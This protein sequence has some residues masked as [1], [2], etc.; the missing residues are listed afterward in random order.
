MIRKFKKKFSLFA[1]ICMSCFIVNN[2]TINA[3]NNHSEVAKEQSKVFM[4]GAA[5]TNITPPLGEHEWYTNKLDT[6]PSRKLPIA[7]HVHDDL[8]A[9]CLMLDDGK[10]KLVFVIID[11]IMVNRELCDE[12]KWLIKEETDIPVENILISATHTHS[13]GSGRLSVLPL[14]RYQKF[15]IKRLADLVRIAHNNMEPARIGWGAGNVPDHVFVR[16]WKMKPES[17]V[18]NPFGGQDQVMMNPGIGNTNIVEPA[19]EPDP[20]VSF[21]SVQSIDGRPIALLANYGLHYVGGV[22][23]GH[24]SADYFALF[25]D[26]IQE[27]L[28]ADRQDPVFVGIMSNGTAGDVNNINFSEEREVNPPYEKMRRVADD[29]AREVFRV[30][31][32]IEF[33]DWVPLG[34]AHSEL[35][36]KVRKPDNKAVIYA[37][38]ALKEPDKRIGPH[39]SKKLYNE[40][41]LRMLE[42]PDYINVIIQTFRIG[43]LGVAAIPFETFAETGLEIKAKSPFKQSFVI[44]LAN[45]N[46]DYLPTPEQHKLGGYETWL[47]T[48]KVEEEA[49]TKIVATLL[50]QFESMK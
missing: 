27:L 48:N 32:K 21:I 16:R 1:V 29:V 19:S 22:P 8:H 26:R 43:D 9:R 3:K 42:W 40:R 13:I 12:A 44:E 14:N 15:V 36:L 11:N 38:N 37:R 46:Y 23:R 49:S 47:S 4:A 6:N 17:D 5:I 2:Q 20:E 39:G 33:H 7:S 25:A 24:I 28:K 18:S 31:N 35:S 50:E 41:T 34:V 10:T 45:G 30:H